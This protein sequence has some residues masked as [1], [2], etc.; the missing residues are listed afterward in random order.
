[1]SGDN[2]VVVTGSGAV[3]SL[4]LDLEELW[5]KLLQGCATRDPVTLFETTGCRCRHAAQVPLPPPPFSQRR[6]SRASRLALRAA[7]EALRQ[8]GLSG[9]DRQ[10]TLLSVSTTG[11]AME[12]GEAFFR[13]VL[14]SRRSRKISHVAGYQPQKQVFDLQKLLGIG[15]PATIFANACASGATAIGHGYDLIR[16]GLADRVLAGGYEALSE[17]IF[18]GFDCLQALSTQKCRPFDQD[19]DGLMLGE[20]AAF[21]VLESE[22]SACRRGVRILG[23]IRGYGH[24]T[25]LHHLTQPSPDGEA[26]RR[27]VQ[28]ALRAAG[29]SADMIGYINAHGTGTPA[30]DSVEAEVYAGVFDASWGKLCLSSTKAAI[31]HTLGAAGAIE[32]AITLRAAMHGRPPPQVG[33]HQP[34]PVVASVL[35]RPDSRIPHEKMVMTTNLG[36]GGSNAALILSS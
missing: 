35:A 22:H 32:A 29:A 14:C 13:G 5:G 4:G 19:R 27:A 23:K 21:L 15:G 11:G 36:F 9:P 16:S 1:M 17:L 34:L 18:V 24:A 2:T 30:N 26:L 12:W 25:D 7:E 8:S 10:A 20:G 33:G 6:L 3:A 28:D 31:G